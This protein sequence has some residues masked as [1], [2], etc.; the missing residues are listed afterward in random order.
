MKRFDR[1]L[2]GLVISICSVVG[3]YW[4]F[5]LWYRILVATYRS[6]ALCLGCN[7]RRPAGDTP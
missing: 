4:R 2:I 1:G 5:S 7:M 3:G 6:R